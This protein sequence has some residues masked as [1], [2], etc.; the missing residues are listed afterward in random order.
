M[1][2]QSK[3]IVAYTSQPEQSAPDRKDGV[4][5]SYVQRAMA[6]VHCSPGRSERGLKSILNKKSH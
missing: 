5:G 2:V 1:M 3:C 6:D 4:N